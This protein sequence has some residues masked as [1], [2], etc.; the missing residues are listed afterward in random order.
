MLKGYT[1]TNC[2]LQQNVLDWEAEP[3]TFS[4]ILW[5]I[6]QGGWQGQSSKAGTIIKL[7]KGGTITW[8]R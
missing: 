6:T 5:P 1:G 3:L 4:Q 8:K 7:L 2:G